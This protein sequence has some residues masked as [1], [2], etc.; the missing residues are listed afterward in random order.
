VPELRQKR[1]FGEVVNMHTFIENITYGLIATAITAAFITG[2]ALQLWSA[3]YL[4]TSRGLTV[5]QYSGS[6]LVYAIGLASVCAAL[7]FA[8]R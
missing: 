3:L 6:V 5:K 2:S 1:Y 8:L 7:H 4:L